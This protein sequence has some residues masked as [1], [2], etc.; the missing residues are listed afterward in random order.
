MQALQQ[1][2]R[3]PLLR[4]L[5]KTLLC[6]SPE[7]PVSR[8]L[9]QPSPKALLSGMQNQLEVGFQQLGLIP[10]TPKAGPAPTNSAPSSCGQDSWPPH[11]SPPHPCPWRGETPPRG[12]GWAVTRRQWDLGGPVYQ[13]VGPEVKGWGGGEKQR[14]SHMQLELESQSG[15]WFSG[16][17][18]GLSQRTKRGDG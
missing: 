12:G 15:W 6:P 16:G 18:W 8:T 7:P 3:E 5:Q 4:G 13:T 10:F 2:T 9:P 14:I 17:S 1:V 11:S